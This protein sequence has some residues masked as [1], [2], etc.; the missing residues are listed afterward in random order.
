MDFA[1][2]ACSGKTLGKLLRPGIMAVLANGP[3]H[4]YRIAQRLKTLSLF[5]EGEPDHAGIYRALKTMEEEGYVSSKWDLGE[6]GPARRRYA[7]TRT[8]KQCLATWLKTIREYRDAIVD[9][10]RFA[11]VQTTEER[12]A[13]GRL[14]CGGSSRRARK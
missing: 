3:L 1:E 7:L 6:S 2:C 5:A 9:L 8:G 4:G 12:R 13:T 10:L 11:E 14:A